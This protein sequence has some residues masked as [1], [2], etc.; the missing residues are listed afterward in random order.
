MSPCDLH[1][2]LLL[3]FWIFLITLS[4]CN[5]LLLF[6]AGIKCRIFTIQIDRY[7]ASC[8]PNEKLCTE[9]RPADVKAEPNGPVI[10]SCLTEHQN[11]RLLFHSKLKQL[12]TKQQIHLLWL[13]QTYAKPK[14]WMFLL[15]DFALFFRSVVVNAINATGL[16]QIHVSWCVQTVCGGARDS[17]RPPPPPSVGW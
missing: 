3:L 16:I 15:D 7:I 6:F 10:Y 12:I 13:L 4:Q 17:S 2:A 5:I 11:K 1:I 14:R 8:F 9:T